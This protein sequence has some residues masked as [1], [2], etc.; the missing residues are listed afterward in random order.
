LIDLNINFRKKSVYKMDVNT[1]L[2]LQ[3]KRFYD[4]CI[5]SSANLCKGIATKKF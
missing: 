2:V 3:A 5:A 4:W 1:K